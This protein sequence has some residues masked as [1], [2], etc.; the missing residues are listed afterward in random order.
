MGC[1]ISNKAIAVETKQIVYS[2]RASR[3]KATLRLTPS[4][5]ESLRTRSSLKTIYEVRS[6]MEASRSI[7]DF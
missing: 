1:G 5:R 6:Y 7:E 2:P 4:V 3:N